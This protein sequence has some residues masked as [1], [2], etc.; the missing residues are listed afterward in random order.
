MSFPAMSPVQAV[1]AHAARGSACHRIL[2]VV[3]PTRPGAQPA[4][5]KAARIAASSGAVLEF[6]ICDVEQDIP[7]SWAGSTGAR[8]YRE[9]RR[10]QHLQELYAL[11]A[12]L[13]ARGQSV[14]FACEWHAPLEEGIGHHVIRTHPDLV[15]KG[16]VRSDLAPRVQLTRADWNLIRQVPASLLLAGPRPWRTQPCIGVAVDCGHAPDHSAGLDEAL[17]EQGRA[18]A[19]TVGGT[20][21]IYHVLQVPLHLRGERVPPQLLEAAQALARQCAQRLARS[22]GTDTVRIAHGTVVEGLA[23]LAAEHQPDVLVAGT[24]AWDHPAAPGTAAQ[25]LE[26]VDCDLLVV[27]PPG[28]VNPLPVTED[29]P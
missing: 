8:Q 19:A 11:A 22:A 10:Q 9:I 25:L 16:T 28:Q 18:L 2:V 17:V 27:K 29:Q 4:V 20:P 7:Q 23:H 15:L 21:G 1:A 3:D 24:V 26:R 13:Q 6:Y 5:D 12:P 14:E